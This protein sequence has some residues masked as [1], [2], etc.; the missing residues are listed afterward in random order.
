VRIEDGHWV[1]EQ[2]GA[3]VDMPFD[4]PWHTEM[5]AR[6]GKPNVRVVIAAGH[7]V[8]RCDV[9]RSSAAPTAAAP[10]ATPQ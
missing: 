4:D 6:G 7:E 8:H 10:A 1:C 3:V 2:C 5:H 9:T